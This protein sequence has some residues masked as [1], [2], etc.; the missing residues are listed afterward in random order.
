[1]LDISPMNS[2]GF[3]NEFDDQSNSSY[4]SLDKFLNYDFCFIEYV[5]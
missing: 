5:S 3:L 2:G 4:S 1:M